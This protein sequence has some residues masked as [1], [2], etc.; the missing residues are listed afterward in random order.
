MNLCY[1]SDYCLA[2]MR[3]GAWGLCTILAGHNGGLDIVNSTRTSK[4]MPPPVS[5][6][7]GMRMARRKVLE[8][9][10]TEGKGFPHRMV[11]KSDS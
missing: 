9:Q 11:T 4:S 10:G 2:M 6:I 5:D 7:L 3:S 8:T 1:V